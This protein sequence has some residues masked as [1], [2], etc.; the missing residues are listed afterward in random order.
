MQEAISSALAERTK[1]ARIFLLEIS[2][3]ALL[4]CEV[5]WAIRSMGV[6]IPVRS[7]PLIEVMTRPLTVVEFVGAT[8]VG[9][10]VLFT[11]LGMPAAIGF[12]LSLVKT[13]RS[14]TA[15]GIVIGWPTGAP[16]QCPVPDLHA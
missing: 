1:L 13:L 16:V 10:A 2:A 15:A 9:F 3:Q 6:A 7:A 8:E 5:Y 11:W 14:L 12:T 4:V